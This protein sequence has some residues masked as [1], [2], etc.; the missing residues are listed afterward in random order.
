MDFIKRFFG[1]LLNPRSR[2]GQIPSIASADGDA[3]DLE[4]PAGARRGPRIRDVVINL[5]LMMGSLI[6]LGLFLIVLFGP[7]WAPTNPYIAGEHIVP[8]YDSQKR[9]WISPPLSP[10]AEY[11]LGTDEWGND[12]FSMLLY[13]ARN[14]LI[15]CAFITMVRVLL[16]LIFGAIAGWHEGGLSDSIIMGMT[17]VIASVPM[18]ISSMLLIYVLDIRRGLLVFI[19]ALSGIGWTEIAQ[20]IRGEILVIRKMPY[21]EG[22]RAVGTSN[23]AVI[24][25]HALPN[26]L[27]QLLVITFLELGAVLMLLGEL[28]FV[29]VFIGGGSRIA[30]GDEM[31]GIQLITQSEVPEWGAMLAE[32]YRWLRSKPFIVYP[33]ATAF[34]I[35]VVGFNALGEGLRRLTETYHISTIFLLRKRMLLVIAALTFAT[36]FIINNTGPAPWFEKVA[37][38][39]DGN[40]AYAYTEMLS[41]MEGRSSAQDGGREAA[42][43]IATKFEAYGLQPGWRSSEYIYPLETQLVQPL[44]QPELILVGADG[45]ALTTFRHQLDFGYRIEGHSGGGE[46]EWPLTFVG[47]RRNEG[48]YNWESFIGL[49]LRDR[50][51]V[52]V[53]GNAPENFVS[54][55]LIRGARGVLWVTGDAFYDVRSQIQLADP[56]RAY[57][58][59]PT[60]PVFNVRPS[61][62]DRILQQDQLTLADLFVQDM[63]VDQ[64]GSGW[65]THDLNTVVR[66]SLSLGEP[67]AV[68]VP[69][70]LGFLP[71][72]DVDLAH[73]MVVLFAHY[74]GLGTDPDG[75]VFPG[76]NHNASGMGILLE[77]ARLWQKQ[78]LNPRRPV[79]FIAWGAGQLD[80]PGAQV[81][82]ENERSFSHL[83]NL[84][85]GTRIA[86]RVVFQLD[87]LGAGADALLIQSKPNSRLYPRLESLAIDAGIP[88]VAESA[89]QANQVNT[90][91]RAQRAEWISLS[92]TDSLFPPDQDTFSK[93][94]PE[95]LQSVGEILVHLM[96]IIVRETRY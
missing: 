73:E 64:Q 41:A 95:K 17:A 7:I 49:D 72:T 68:Q 65:Y 93:I 40:S 70:V 61:V 62:V 77:I 18:L 54:E 13:G 26:L 8:H 79:L 56:S 28:G 76:A 37:R 46:A 20:Y 36:V 51:V 66:M 25:W 27:P 10:S 11:P 33:P 84:N 94:Q 87:N 39:F 47:F 80:D 14:T 58:S 92:W 86:P 83:P 23:L 48:S 43:Y 31:T 3:Q 96:T 19:I 60:I 78:E 12:I 4:T 38:A 6:V 1:L 74:D 82:L 55:A 75:T 45:R 89:A 90:I 5:P 88:I 69:C 29:G 57:L 30:L 67:Q 52:L 9:D 16:G 71:G 91:A 22:A 81:F 21:M 32:G 44:E 50:I 53:Q 59:K 15:A 24:V 63:Q 42:E 85:A 2:L 34:F 35:A